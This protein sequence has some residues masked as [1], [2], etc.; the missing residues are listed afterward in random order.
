MKRGG[1]TDELI[2]INFALALEVDIVK[3]FV[4]FVLGGLEGLCD[5]LKIEE[6]ILI[7]KDLKLILQ[8]AD[9]VIVKSGKRLQVRRSEYFVAHEVI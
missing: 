1:S 5:F 4:G 3:Y 7:A 6:L 8:I 9:L 2:E